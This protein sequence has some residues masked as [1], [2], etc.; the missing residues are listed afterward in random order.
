MRYT[1]KI[2]DT[3]RLLSTWAKDVLGSEKARVVQ[4][5]YQG[6]SLRPSRVEVTV[7]DE[8]YLWLAMEF[9]EPYGPED[10]PSD[11]V[12]VQRG[13]I[14]SILV[15]FFAWLV[16]IAVIHSCADKHKPYLKP[17]PT[18]AVDLK[19]QAVKP[20]SAIVTPHKGLPAVEMPA[21]DVTA[22][23]IS[24]ELNAAVEAV[25]AQGDCDDDELRESAKDLQT[26]FRE[27]Y[28]RSGK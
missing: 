19:P 26:A 4:V 20:I 6:D 7:N 10:Q 14:G 25:I 3:V 9:V 12:A 16:I 18:K 8:E 23:I 13:A 22:V 28:G 1:P 15:G 11:P 27:A 21:R 17:I 2:G 24:P 5:S